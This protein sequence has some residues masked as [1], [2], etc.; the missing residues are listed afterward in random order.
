MDTDKLILTLMPAETDPSLRS[1]EYQRGL[2]KLATAFSAQGMKVSSVVELEESEG[3]SETILLG[4][5]TIELA[6]IAAPVIAG[7]IGAWLQARYGRTARLKI[8]DIEAEAR[9]VEEVEK[10]IAR[11]KRLQ[12][13]KQ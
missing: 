1:P 10:L 8:G 12:Q 5:Y 9:T 6:K 13:T 7:I 4:K 2:N 3:S 11:A